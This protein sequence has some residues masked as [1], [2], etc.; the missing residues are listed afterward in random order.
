MLRR[1]DI[2]DEKLAMHSK[3]IARPR[4]QLTSRTL[5]SSSAI[6]TTEALVAKGL[7]LL[8]SKEIDQPDRNWNI[9]LG[10]V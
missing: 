4:F 10:T 2:G 7:T 8:P 1:D 6:G 3:G 5:A 9:E